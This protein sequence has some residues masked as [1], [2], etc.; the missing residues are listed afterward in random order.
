MYRVAYIADTTFSP[1]A[2]LQ[3]LR[4]V[5]RAQYTEPMQPDALVIRAKL[6]AATSSKTWLDLADQTLELLRNEAPNH[7]RLPDAEAAIHLRRGDYEAAITCFDT[8]IANP[9]SP[10]EQLVACAHRASAMESLNRYDDALDA[11]EQVLRLDPNDALVWH[12]MSLLL[13]K[14]S[15]LEEALH[16]NTRALS[17][18]DFSNA[19]TTRE[20]IL[21]ELR[22]RD[23]V[24]DERPS[25]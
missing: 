10:E 18:M 12:N 23:G 24:T 14:Q 2:L 20:R 7:P 8:L 9:P 22:Q 3:G 15:R 25:E 21:T 4:Y 17:I 19:R 5:A 13:M 11:Y 16:A 6:L 1:V